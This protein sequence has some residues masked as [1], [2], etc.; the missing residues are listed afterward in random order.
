[1]KDY[2]FR[3]VLEPDEEGWHVYFPPWASI[4]ASTWGYT[5]EEALHYIQEV[6]EM[7]IEEFEEEGTPS[8]IHY[9]EEQA[10]WKGCHITCGGWNCC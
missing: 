5:R 1:M 10:R 3:V 7:I 2:V 6:L 8:P 4:G 9:L